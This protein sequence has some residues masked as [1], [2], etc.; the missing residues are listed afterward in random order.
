MSAVLRGNGGRPNREVAMSL[1]TL[2]KKG[3]E[4]ELQLEH[5]WFSTDGGLMGEKL[6]SA[7]RERC[8]LRRRLKKV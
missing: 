2:G 3:G 8:I 4:D 1:E 7:M 5:D 6:V